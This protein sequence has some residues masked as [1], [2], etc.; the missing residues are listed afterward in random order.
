VTSGFSVA[1]PYTSA[2]KVEPIFFA[3]TE[4]MA[5]V[6]DKGLP[7]AGVD[8]RERGIRQLAWVG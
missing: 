2:R 3:E 6:V 1:S 7:L 5:E 4:I 8:V